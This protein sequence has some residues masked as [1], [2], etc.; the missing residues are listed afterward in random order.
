MEKYL[1]FPVLILSAFLIRPIYSGASIGDAL[2][3]IGL[4][5]LYG[6]HYYLQHKKEP[7]ANKDLINRLVDL[8]EQVKTTKETIYSIKLASSL[9]R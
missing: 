3:I 2:V 5:A 9:K 4:S 7:T 8:E 6:A 1:N